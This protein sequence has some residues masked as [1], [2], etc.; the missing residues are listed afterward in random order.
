[1]NP[2]IKYLTSEDKLLIPQ[3]L[4]E[5]T[6]MPMVHDEDT[7]KYLTH[8]ANTGLALLEHDNKSKFDA[9]RLIVVSCLAVGYLHG[10]EGN[11]SS[12]EVVSDVLKDLNIKEGK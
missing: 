1:M 12:A 11:K 3:K 9:L 7:G 4:Y 6:I 8:I 2:I 5:E 10:A